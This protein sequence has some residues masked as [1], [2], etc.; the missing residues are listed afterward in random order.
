[1]PVEHREPDRGLVA[2]G[3]GQRLLAVRAAGHRRVAVTAREFGQDAS[4]LT[5][6]LLDDLETI[7]DLQDDRGVHDVLGGRPPVDVAPGLTALLHHLMDERQDRIAYDVGLLAQEVEVEG[8]HVSAACDLLGGLC[9]THAATR[10]VLS[11]RDLDLG[12]ASDE[13][14][15]GEHR[16]HLRGAEGV[17]EQDRVEDRRGSRDGLLCHAASS[18]VDAHGRLRP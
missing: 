3:D 9:R 8:G 1:M 12:V 5:E 17:A 4:Q 16:P 2:E 14:V 6:I 7:A 13:R 10:L 15:I 18:G 11:E